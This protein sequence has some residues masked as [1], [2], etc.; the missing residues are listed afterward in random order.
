MDNVVAL[1]YNLVFAL[2]RSF[3]GRFG[4]SRTNC[5]LIY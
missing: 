4:V 3:I 1:L 2:L 5:D